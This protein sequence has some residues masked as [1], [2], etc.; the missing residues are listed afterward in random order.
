MGGVSR[1]NGDKTEVL[2]RKNRGSARSSSFL[3][4]HHDPP[5]KAGIPE[6][7]IDGAFVRALD[8]DGVEVQNLMDEHT[9]IPWETAEQMLRNGDGLKAYIRLR[10]QG[11][12]GADTLVVE[13]LSGEKF[14][15]E[16]STFKRQV[17]PSTYT[18]LKGALKK[19]IE[20]NNGKFNDPMYAGAIGELH[21]HLGEK[22]PV[23]TPGNVRKGIQE[24]LSEPDLNLG[25]IKRIIVYDDDGFRIARFAARGIS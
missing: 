7:E 6:T 22:S 13:T 4:W 9:L 21:I 11:V 5:G 12:S 19:F 17:P 15:L 24:I 25:S 8:P 23:S 16:F 1:L 14:A 18:E 2:R 3:G 10:G 20:S